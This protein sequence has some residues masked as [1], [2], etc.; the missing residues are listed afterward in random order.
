MHLWT[1]I[2]FGTPLGRPHH[3]RPRA[4]YLKNAPPAD[5]HRRAP[6]HPAPAPRAGWAGR[7]ARSLASYL[8]VT[9]RETITLLCR[10]GR[11]GAVWAR[12]GSNVLSYNASD[13]CPC[14]LPS[15][16]LY[17]TDGLRHLLLTLSGLGGISPVKHLHPLQCDGHNSLRHIGRRRHFSTSLSLLP[18]P[19][20]SRAG[21]AAAFP[22]H[23]SLPTASTFPAR[24]HAAQGGR[25]TTKNAR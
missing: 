17:V 23:C 21:P 7:P 24:T 18:P 19:S 15:H 6:P 3:Y 16:S 13:V 22:P 4:A 11:R 14:S 12:H 8:S 5:H 10:H 1:N 25:V 20:A 2:R 9:W